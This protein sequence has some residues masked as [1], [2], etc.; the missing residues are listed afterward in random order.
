MGL[1]DFFL[2]DAKKI[3]RYQRALV[4]KAQ[5]AEERAVSARWLADHGTPIALLALLSRFEMRLEHQMNDQAEKEDL[6]GLLIRLGEPVVEPLRAH[7]KKG[8]QMGFPLR[9]MVE[10]QGVDRTVDLVLDLLEHERKKD[11]FKA[12]KKQQLLVWLAEGRHARA[13]PVAA[14]FL[15]DFDEAVRYSAA[16]VL[17]AS[18]DEASR[19][20][21]EGTLVSPKEESNRLKTR[22]A[23]VFA[24]KGWPL[25]QPEAVAASLPGGF[26]VRNGR[27][28]ASGSAG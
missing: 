7:L 14:A 5:Q 20:A 4:D 8:R 10:L 18:G 23:D 19:L 13:A 21:L 12:D 1:F 26:V 22:I 27:V 16:E 6:Y 15:H 2:S 28:V 3:Q 17:M 25:A 24:S 11:D 9:L